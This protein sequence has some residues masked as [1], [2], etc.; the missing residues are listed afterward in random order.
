M[1][2]C[3]AV[4]GSALAIHVLVLGFNNE[5][6]IIYVTMQVVNLKIYVAN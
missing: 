5:I 3:M 4:G 1:L 2:V 6:K